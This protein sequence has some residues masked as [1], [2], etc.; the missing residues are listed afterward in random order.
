MRLYTP[1]SLLYP[2][3]VTKLL[4][5]QGDSIEVNSP[6]FLYNYK[7]VVTEFDEDAREDVERERTWPATFESELEGTL[8]SLNVKVG[9]VIERKTPIADVEEACKHEIQFAGL[10]AACGQDMKEKSSYNETTA[11]AA[12]ATVNT[13]H[14]RQDLLISE[15]EASKSDEE[16]KRRLLESRRLSLVVDLDQT[17]IHASVEPTIGEWQNDPSNPNYEALRDVQA[18]QLHDDKPNTWYYIKPRPGLK[19]FLDRLSEIYEMHIYTMGTRSYAENV[20]KIIDPDRKIFGDRIVT[21]NESGSQTAKYLKRLFPIDTRM[22]VIIDDRADVWHWISNL[23][24]VNVFEFFVGIGDINSSFLPKRPELEA[25]KAHAP[26]M[27]RIPSNKTPTENGDNAQ[28]DAS[29]EPVTTTPTPASPVQTNG[30]TSVSE[31]LLTMAGPQDA[32]TIQEKTEEQEQIIQEQLD[33]R[34]MLKKQK[35]LEDLA[36]EEEAK[37]SPAV[38]ATAELLAENGDDTETKELS[39]VDSIQH[40]Y[41]QNLLADDDNELVYLEQ[42]L[43]NV[44][45]TYYDEYDKQSRGAKGDRVAEL[46]PGHSKKRSFDDLNNIPDAAVLMDGIKAKVLAGC[47]IVF[48]GVVPLGVDPLTHDA[49]LW[50]KTFGATVSVNITKKTTHVIASPDRRTAKVRQAAK[51][52]RIAIVSQHWLHACF[53]QWKNVDVNPYRIHSDA[54]ANGAGALPESFDETAYNVSSS[55]DDSILTEDET[56]ATE[57]PNGGDRLTL[58]IDTDEEELMKYAPSLDRKDSSP[59]EGEQPDDFQAIDEELE[60]FME[61]SG[62][63]DDSDTESVKSTQSETEPSSAK[64]RTRDDRDSDGESEKGSRLQK[65][66]KQA[67]ERTSSLTNLVVQGNGAA[68]AVEGQDEI[69]GTESDADLE[70]QLAAEMERQSDGEE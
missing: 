48:S 24:K 42:S 54:P 9:Q 51:K 49:A 11:R 59:I 67:M 68:P 61:E 37:A 3:T 15:E 56:D 23:V 18:F 35:E 46:R 20:A 10:C 25:A 6:L 27:E 19:D 12:R 22:V 66:K 65:R 41:R 57:T 52:P 26:K 13:V 53:A 16:A 40:K 31:Q 36:K 28:P 60:A 14:G 39:H 44:H 7:S 50:A 30:E 1:D 43:R 38:E 34:P 29:T 21:R 70:A 47:H 17:I 69:E 62:D 58:E 4:R 32:K 55:D 63:E 64:K 45:T 33:D 2:I 5:K 8:E